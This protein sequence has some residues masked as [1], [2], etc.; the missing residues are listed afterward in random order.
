[1]SAVMEKRA[2][3]RIV[4]TLNIMLLALVSLICLLPFVHMVAKSFSGAAAVSAGRVTF[5]PIDFTLNTYRYVLQ[6]SLFFSSFRNSV[7]ITAG[8][9]LLS[10][11]FTV[12]AAYP[13]SK[14]HLRG[15]RVILLLYVFTMLFYGGMVSIYVFMRTLNLLNTLACQIIPLLVSQYNLFVMKTFFEGIPESIEESA[16]IDGAGPLRTLM[17]IVLPLSLPS[18]ATIGLFYAVAY[19]N[20]YY[21]PM[22]FITRADVK[23]LQMYL[24]EL[25]TTT[26]NLYEVD[27]VI[28]AGLS[29]SGMQAAAIVVSTL[30]ILLVYPFL[31]KYFIKGLTV[32]SVKG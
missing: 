28:A 18:L 17:S 16:H 5:Y 8:G 10:L 13:L 7:T 9:T 4:R 11:T 27:P 24:Y 23:P 2:G 19:W 32:G 1:M 21:H 31:Q 6:D 30:P 3:A 15:R 22:L 26:Q 29:S 25:I 12:L 20:N 14:Q